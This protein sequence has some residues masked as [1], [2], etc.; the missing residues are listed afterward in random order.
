MSHPLRAVWRMIYF[1]KEINSDWHQ[2]IELAK[3]SQT[4][5]GTCDACCCAACCNACGKDGYNGKLYCGLTDETFSD[6]GA[7]GAS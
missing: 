2:S 6:W 7:N 3:A 5:D 1:A 4:Y